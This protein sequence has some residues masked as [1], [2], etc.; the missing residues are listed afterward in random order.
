MTANSIDKLM[1]TYY[2]FW[3]VIIDFK[4]SERATAPSQ[5][6][7]FLPRLRIEIRIDTIKHYDHDIINPMKLTGCRSTYSRCAVYMAVIRLALILYRSEL[8]S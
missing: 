8:E 4:L 3:R 2:N 7:E 1:S 5:P 6:M